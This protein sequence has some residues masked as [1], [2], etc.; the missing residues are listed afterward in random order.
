M[1]DNQ[2]SEQ[3]IAEQMV[4]LILRKGFSS[5][6]INEISELLGVQQDNIT[7]Y[8]DSTESI[9][10]YI[11]RRMKRE[12]DQHIFSI[13]DDKSLNE[14]ERLVKINQLLK[15][16]FL[17]QKGCLIAAMGMEKDTV[18]EEAVEIMNAIFFDWKQTYTKL[19]RSCHTPYMAD[20]LATNAII[21]IEGAIIW[22]RVTG[23]DEP[24]IRV[25]NDIDEKLINAA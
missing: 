13:A 25:F 3:D 6:S 1:I 23:E 8:F 16:Y 15:E 7:S 20:Q 17:D 2:I 4:R 9:L 21:F 24:L 14:L 10:L 18:S 19:Y 11:L 12:L 5:I 22:L